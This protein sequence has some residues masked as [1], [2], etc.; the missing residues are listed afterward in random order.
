MV[1]DVIYEYSIVFGIIAFITIYLLNRIYGFEFMRLTDATR[2]VDSVTNYCDSK[3]CVRCNTYKGTLTTAAVKLRQID[4]TEIRN[5][6]EIGITRIT[7][8]TLDRQQP[9]VFFYREL[10]S[11]PTWDSSL[12]VECSIL[13]NSFKV[14]RKEFDSLIQQEYKGIWK[15]NRT[16]QGSWDVFHLINQGKEVPENC[17]LCP[18]TT[19]IIDSLTSAMKNNVFGNVMFSVVRPETVITEHYGPTN[20]RL[21]CHLGL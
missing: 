3:D 13:E 16:Q 6:L 17:E 5:R 4:D 8:N 15:N 14:I 12:F 10:E 9:N 18:G 2:N 21:R 20:I 19:D 11:T 7:F 1:L